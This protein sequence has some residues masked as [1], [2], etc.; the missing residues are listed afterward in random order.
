MQQFL[1]ANIHR[2]ST[3]HVKKFEGLIWKSSRFFGWRSYWVV[4]QDGVLSWY[5]KQ[6]DAAANVRRQGCKSLTNSH[7]LIRARDDCFFTLKCFD[8]SVH[9]FK[10]SPKADPEATR[11]AGPLLSPQLQAAKSPGISQPLQIQKK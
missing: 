3:R 8:D 9:H 2:G 1:E 7:C 4:L 5:S 6:S 10:V 11:K